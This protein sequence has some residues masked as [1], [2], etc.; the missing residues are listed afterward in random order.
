MSA[1]A[2]SKSLKELRIHFSQNSAASRGLRRDFIIKTYPDLKKANP[3][4]PILIREAAGVES[5]II[6]RFD[7]GRERKVVVDNFNVGDVEQ[8]FNT[9]VSEAN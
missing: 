2:F 8:K 6:A 5:R 1:R 7:Q 9:L 4:L 3:G